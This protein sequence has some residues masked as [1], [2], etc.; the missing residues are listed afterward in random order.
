MR[1]KSCVEFDAG[2]PA[3]VVTRESSREHER[4][5]RR[6]SRRADI[7]TEKLASLNAFARRTGKGRVE[8]RSGLGNGCTCLI[9]HHAACH[10]RCFTARR[11]MLCIHE[12]RRSL[13][14]PGLRNLWGIFSSNRE[15]ESA[16]CPFHARER[17]RERERKGDGSRDRTL[18]A[19][20]TGRN[21]RARGSLRDYTSSRERKVNH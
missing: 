9:V 12:T 1:E 21:H 5:S 2:I 17:E 16:S 10:P 13:S 8:S 18:F 15:M 3:C 4:A 11:T 7:K 20:L 6:A 19:T 14:P